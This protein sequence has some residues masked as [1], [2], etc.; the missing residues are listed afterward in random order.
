MDRCPQ[1]IVGSFAACAIGEV[2]WN[3]PKVPEPATW[4]MMLAGFV[5]VGFAIRRK[6]VAV[7]SA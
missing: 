1:P 7:V 3:G 6:G 5:L 2:A 4:A